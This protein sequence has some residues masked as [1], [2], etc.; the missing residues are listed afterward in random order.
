MPVPNTAWAAQRRNVMFAKF[1]RTGQG[2]D[3]QQSMNSAQATLIVACG[4]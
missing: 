3:L 2:Q 1:A 4:D